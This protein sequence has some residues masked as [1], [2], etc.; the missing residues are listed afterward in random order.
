MWSFS[1]LVAA[2]VRQRWSEAGV[3]GHHGLLV[4]LVGVGLGT[5]A[6]RA[7]STWLSNPGSSDLNTA[8]NWV[9]ATVPTNGTAVF[10]VSNTTTITFSAL[11]TSVGTFQFNTLAPAYSFNLSGQTLTFNGAGIFDQSSNAPSFSITNGTLAFSS[12]VAC[13]A[14]DSTIINNAGLT[15]FAQTGT[16]GTAVITNNSGTT[17]F[18]DTSTAGNSTITTNS[19][20]VT[21]FTDTSTG[22]QARFITNSGGIFDISEL[23]SAGMTVGSIEGGGTYRLGSKALTVGLNNLSTEVTGTITDGGLGSGAGG[24]LIKVGIGTLTLTGANTYSGATTISAGTLQAGSP[25]GFSANSAFTVNSVLDLNGF[26]NTVGS[27]AGSGTVTNNGGTPATLTAGGDNT[28]TSFGG[29]LQDG[30]ASLGLTK[31]GSGTLTLTGPNTYSCGT[32]FNGGAVAVNSDSNLGAGPLSFDS[33]TLEVL[34]TGGGITSNKAIRLSPLGG[35]IQA[36]AGTTS[37]LS[38]A[39]SG[40]GSLNSSSGTLRMSGPGTLILSGVN[41]Y[42][43]ITVV[44]GGT[45]EAG[46]FTAFSP[47]AGMTVFS[48]LDLNGFDNTVAFLAGNGIVTNSGA[49]LANLTVGTNIAGAPSTTFDGTLKDGASA[50][51]LTVTTGQ[52]NLTAANTYSGGTNIIN[53]GTV[54]VQSDSNL[55]SGPLKFDDGTLFLGAPFVPV[56][57]NKAVTLNSGGGTF[58]VSFLS[59]AT[60]SGPIIGTGALTDFGVGALILTGVNTYTGGTNI[61]LGKVE[62][63]SDSNLGTGPL[64]FD[65]G[66]LEALARGGGIVSSKAITLN[67]GGGTFLT[68]AGT[69]STMSGSISGPGS[70]T[71]DGPG[72]LILAGANTYRGA[73]SVTLGTLQAG[74]STALSANSAFTVTSVLDLNG[75]NNTIGSLA[76]TGMV[77]NNGGRSAILTVGARNTDTIFGGT[78]T[79]GNSALQLT[80]TGTATLIL[81]GSNTY[82]GPT[83][84]V[85]GTLAA[86]SSTAFSTNSAFTV[87]SV[88]DLNGFHNAIGSLAGTGT[89]TN[90]GGISANLTVGSNNTNTTFSGAVTDSAGPLELTKIG[91]GILTLTGLNNSRGGTNINGGILA[92]NSDSNLGTGP[93]SLNGG[94]LEALAGGRGI[95]SSKAITL[96]SEGGTFLAEVGTGSTLGGEISGAGSLTID[97]PGTLALTALNIY[98]GGT[99]MNGGILGVDSDSNLGTGALVFNGGALEALAPG[100]GIISSKAT[101]LDSGGGT[102]VGGAGTSSILSG[103][104]NGVGSLTKNGP[105][106]LVLAGAN[107]YS[108]GTALNGGILTVH[109]PQALGVGNLVVN[110]GILNADPQ[111]IVVK[112]NYTQ[113]AGGTLQLQVAGASPGQYDSL[114]VGGNAKLSGTLQLLSLGFQPKAGNQLTLVA[115]GGVV[116]GQFAQLLNPFRAGPGFNTVEVVY[117]PNSVLLAFLNLTEPVVPGVPGSP[118]VP[119]SIALSKVSPG[120]LTAIYDIGFSNANIQRLN[121]EDRLEAIRAGCTG[122]SSNMNLNVATTNPGGKGVVDGKSSQVVVEPI[123]QPGCE[124]HWGVWVTGFGDFVNVDGDANAKGYNFTTGGVTLGIDYRITDHLAIGLMG[125]YAHTWTTLQPVGHIDVDSGRGGLYG[126]WYDR[127]IYLNGGIFAG[128]NT[129]E[130]GRSNVGGLSTGG[131]EGADWNAF[132][133]GGYD[134][135]FKALTV[136]PIGSLQYTSVNLDGFT[137]KGS[138]APLDIHSGSVAS[139]RSDVGFRAFYQWQIGKIS[140]RPAIKA[141][142]E[143]EYKYS[144]LPI[145][146][147]FADFSSPALTFFGPKQGQ[148]SAVVSAGISAQCTSA[149]S[150]Y[151]NY[152]GQL[153]RYHYDSNAVTGGFSI[154]F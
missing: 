53:G 42:G 35:T 107:T 51:Q 43:G 17:E 111:Q 37:T 69:T 12:A 11:H 10:D 23:S 56:T 106:R 153:G 27:L 68:D 117:E 31:V 93:L 19:T 147:G 54:V 76:G 48:V 88:L 13:T 99:V 80:K 1:A 5:V 50:L 83:N 64:S 33:G 120:D 144:A 85:L 91:T 81:A 96:H 74:S 127:G 98:T 112:G 60:F 134:F 24:A 148:D 40:S 131:S 87:A 29:L 104:I 58:E 137:E 128:H 9:P 124:N 34:A 122:F 140:V 101:T 44:Q 103:P 14:G 75:F 79:D 102:F 92:V 105:G 141:A 113:N 32:S 143:H 47:N 20:G 126:T 55:G 77:T 97:G 129:Y 89:V 7:Q 145:T 90:G 78:L 67:S 8:T 136:G 3:S 116:S 95:V 133:G 28:S 139:L 16:A 142:W 82:T 36:D 26:S 86:G 149:I 18:E 49:S 25:T 15:V 138:F 125:E 94:A 52:L 100:G 22:G 109:G 72:T 123:F 118:I 4:L 132:V 121:V 84:V 61:I 115:T 21:F 30:N 65:S 41:T 152:D 6:A 70:W 130:I 62:V 59:T 45:L 146:A 73:T 2:N 114:N 135:H 154:S 150:I 119:V 46:S 71:K 63:N 110:G 57:S 38:G 66:T 151:V 39:I 108:G